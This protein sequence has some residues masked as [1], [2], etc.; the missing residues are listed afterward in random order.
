M[1]LGSSAAKVSFATSVPSGFIARLAR[2]LSALLLVAASA[3]AGAGEWTFDRAAF[4]K[5]VASG[6]PV[7]VHIAATWCPTCKAQ[8]PLVDALLRELQVV[9]EAI[10]IARLQ[11]RVHKLCERVFVVLAAI[12]PAGAGFRFARGFDHVRRYP[13]GVGKQRRIVHFL[14]RPAAQQNLVEEV[15]LVRPRRGPAID[16]AL[17]QPVHAAP[18]REHLPPQRGHFRE[19]VDAHARILG[20]LSVVG[21]G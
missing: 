12:G 2:T 19:Y 5:A 8:K 4:D 14:K 16:L 1:K 11:E 18:A 9:Q 6:R 7:I 20:A 10:A 3:G 13:L 17:A 15:L 21:G